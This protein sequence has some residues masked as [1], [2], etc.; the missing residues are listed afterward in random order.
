MI[1]VG[2]RWVSVEILIFF[3]LLDLSPHA[4]ACETFD[5]CAV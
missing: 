3:D 4:C 5:P 1:D 2:E